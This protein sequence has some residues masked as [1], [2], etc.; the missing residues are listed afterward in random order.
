MIFLKNYSG[1]NF[2]AAAAPVKK[3]KTVFSAPPP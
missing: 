1:L 2:P 3:I